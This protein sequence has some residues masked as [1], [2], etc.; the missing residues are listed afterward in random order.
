M[1]EILENNR[2]VNLILNKEEMNFKRGD[3][4]KHNCKYLFF[5][6]F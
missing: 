4:H 1:L 2:G 6:K 5:L 3:N